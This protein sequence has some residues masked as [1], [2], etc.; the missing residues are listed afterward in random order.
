[1]ELT[2]VGRYRLCFE[3]ASGGMATVCLARIGGPHGFE[4]LVALKRIHPHLVSERRYVEIFLDEARI[5]S[6]I[7]HPNVCSV[8]DLGES[9]GEYLLAMEYLVGEPLARLFRRAAASPEQR[10]S[11]LLALKMARIIEEACE[12]LHAAHESRD[13]NGQPLNVVQRDVSPRNLFMTYSG[14]VHV[15]DFGIALGRYIDGLSQVILAR[16]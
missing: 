15:V 7:P 12:G 10:E 14:V 3:L 8:F 1:M 16:R 6:G 9:E 4:K 13:A 2:Q 11:P 5:A